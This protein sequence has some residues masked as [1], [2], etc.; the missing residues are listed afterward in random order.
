MSNSRIIIQ[1]FGSPDVLSV[2]EEPQ[3]PEPGPGQVRVK[4]QASGVAFTDVMIRKGVYPDVKENPPFTPGYDLVGEVD[5][6][7]E[8]VSNLSLGDRVAELT[9]IGA[10]AE[11]VCLDAN[12]LVPVPQELDPAQAV[13]LV[14]SY[15]TAYQMLIR[16]AGLQA[17]Q[18]ILVHG[19]G[20]VVGSALTQLGNLFDL[21]VYGT[22]S[23]PK[24]D[25]VSGLG[26][27]PIDYR[28]EDFVS[29]INR[30][31]PPGA[32]AVFDHIGG[33]HFKRS[34]RC[35]RPGGRLIAYGFY[36]ATMG[37]GGSIPLDFLRLQLWNLLPNKR[38]AG[39]YSIGPLRKKRPDLFMEDLGNLFQLTL[40]GEIQPIIWKKISLDQIPE[41][42][43][44]I[45]AAE[46]Q[47]KI[48]CVF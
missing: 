23:A 8:G 19:A 44:W 41:A 48:V 21:E 42:H 46:A 34:F 27:V 29:V 30:L 4:T 36:H 1:E 37:R 7:G 22:A 11:Y 25:L 35:L 43:R 20:G 17:G 33:D 39:L 2:V 3:L 5:R 6:L 15:T 14:L 47:G 10:Q 40:N 12:H 16:E 45:E 9:V 32:D 26:A 13:S 24:H 38:K 18:R 31:T 28:K